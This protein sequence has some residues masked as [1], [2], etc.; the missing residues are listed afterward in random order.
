MLPAA[1]PA[2]PRQLIAGGRH[3]REPE[4]L[5]K[6]E[7]STSQDE[8][9]TATW[10]VISVC[11]LITFVGFNLRSVILAVPP[12]LPLIQHDLGL[13]YATT[14]LLT[15]LPVL[16]L[17]GGAWPSGLL[18]E[19]IGAWPC[20]SIG[21]V[22]VGAGTL[23]RAFWPTAFL[24]FLFTL[25]L[26]LGIVLTQATIP[27][28]IHH[29]F[30]EHIGLVAALFSDGL[31][32]GEAVAAGELFPSCYNFWERTPGRAHSFCGA[33]LYSSCSLS[34]SGLPRPHIQRYPGTCFPY[35]VL[36]HL[37]HRR[38]APSPPNGHVS[39]PCTWASWSALAASS[40][41]A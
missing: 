22:L 6:T 2:V 3:I 24:L 14:G 4:T 9:I 21:L 35:N 11:T 23:L 36:R 19:R 18:A 1:S 17:A 30:P 16:A 25:L 31:I 29:W 34:G 20:V 32:I 38:A 5:V 26:S 8:R 33:S 7:A 12:V 28:L 40:I 15:A 37:R 10:R 41:S 27:V 39:A 13:S